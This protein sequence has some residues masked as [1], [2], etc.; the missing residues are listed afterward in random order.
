MPVRT[1]LPTLPVP[2]RRNGVSLFALRSVIRSAAID[3]LRET[4]GC[5]GLFCGTQVFFPGLKRHQNGPREVGLDTCALI[6]LAT[7][8]RLL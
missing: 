8:K 5:R 2:N 3:V 1:W 6:S 7:A 4:N